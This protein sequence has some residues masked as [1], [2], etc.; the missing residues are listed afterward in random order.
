[1]STFLGLPG[2][3][4]RNASLALNPLRYTLSKNLVSLIFEYRHDSIALALL[5][6]I[7]T[8]KKVAMVDRLDTVR[9]HSKMLGFRLSERDVWSVI[10]ALANGDS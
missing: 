4:T 5:L 3:T 2:V 7:A 8:D 6:Q 1:M 9:V 10:A